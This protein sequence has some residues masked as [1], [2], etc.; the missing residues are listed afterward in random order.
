MQTVTSTSTCS[1]TKAV[2]ANPSSGRRRSN[3]K[4]ARRHA[5]QA[6]NWCEDFFLNNIGVSQGNWD[7]Q[8]MVE[9]SEE[10]QRPE[11][12]TAIAGRVVSIALHP[13]AHHILKKVLHQWNTPEWSELIHD[14]LT[15]D[16]GDLVAIAMSPFGYRVVQLLIRALDS[17]DAD[18]LAHSLAMDASNLSKNE[19]GLTVLLEV[20]RRDVRDHSYQV[21]RAVE[22][23]VRTVCQSDIGRELVREL[24]DSGCQSECVW[25]ARAIFGFPDLL[26]AL[27]GSDDGASIAHTAVGLVSA[28]ER[29][30]MQES[31][32][33]PTL[34]SLYRF[35][36]GKN[37][38]DD[39][40]RRTTV[41]STE[42]PMGYAR[43]MSDTGSDFG[44]HS[45]HT[46]TT[47]DFAAFD[48]P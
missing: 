15:R 6:A 39:A 3:R 11:L 41:G 1:S 8:L 47:D 22:M 2:S 37:V 38:F 44:S 34:K 4:H 42:I 19:H 29:E 28:S 10:E 32:S 23:N 48:M 18:R 20:V 13:V 46:A 27:L 45:F 26:G 40:K 16:A 14:E 25:L 36:E 12:M 9:N 7:A 30:R 17:F 21:R 43:T 35:A 5:R 31:L 24:L 33:D